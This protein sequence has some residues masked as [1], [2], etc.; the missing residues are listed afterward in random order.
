M[1]STHIIR[2]LLKN[3]W[4]HSVN[5]SLLWVMMRLSQPTMHHLLC[6]LRMWCRR[7]YSSKITREY[8][9]NY[10]YRA[11]KLHQELISLLAKTK[12]NIYENFLLPKCSTLVLFR[13][14]HE[15]KD[16]AECLDPIRP[17]NYRR[18]ASNNRKPISSCLAFQDERVCFCCSD[19]YKEPIITLDP[20]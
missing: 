1:T 5:R 13:F 9:T 17:T 12:F 10:T 14:I 11:N 7:C 16:D 8:W 6:K 20:Q 4:T 19:N 3:L 2:F 15:E 18:R